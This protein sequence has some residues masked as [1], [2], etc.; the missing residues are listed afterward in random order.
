MPTVSSVAL[1]DVSSGGEF[2]MVRVPKI[3]RISRRFSETSSLGAVVRS[4]MKSLIDRM[5][6]G[7]PSSSGSHQ[8]DGEIPQPARNLFRRVSG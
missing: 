4:W 6:G 7:H 8:S 1:L 5:M 3:P 2:E